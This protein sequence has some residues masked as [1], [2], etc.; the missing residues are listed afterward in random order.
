MLFLFY[1]SILLS[2]V[3]FTLALLK[4][5]Y[6]F[7]ILIIILAMPSAIYFSGYPYLRFAILVPFIYIALF[8]LA[9][10]MKMPSKH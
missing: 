8:F 1:F 6:L 2:L 3:F 7:L 5:S 10:R 9:K 4:T